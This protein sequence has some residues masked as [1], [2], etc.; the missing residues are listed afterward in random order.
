[1]AEEREAQALGEAGAGVEGRAGFGAEG[2][3]VFEDNDTEGFGAW[4]LGGFG[5]AEEGRKIEEEAEE[6][7]GCF[8]AAQEEEKKKEGGDFEEK[9]ETEIVAGTELAERALEF[10]EEA[11][12]VFGREGETALDE[13]D[14]VRDLRTVA[15][16]AGGTLPAPEGAGGAV[17]AVLA[18]AEVV[19]DATIAFGVFLEPGLK[20]FQAGLVVPPTAGFEGLGGM[21][22]APEGKGACEQASRPPRKKEK[23]KKAAKKGSRAFWKITFH[24]RASP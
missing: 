14:V 19:F 5:G 11:C 20:T 24:R 10:L 6:K 15:E 16:T 21:V 1:L 7:G 22:P 12:A 4:R 3:V 18:I 2:E 9:T 23:E 13:G 17:Q 8:V